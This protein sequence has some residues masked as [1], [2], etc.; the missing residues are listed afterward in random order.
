[1]NPRETDTDGDCIP[2]GA[3]DKMVMEKWVKVRRIP[4]V[5]TATVTGS[6]MV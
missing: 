6:L 4:S 3:E 5:P 1:M 2:D